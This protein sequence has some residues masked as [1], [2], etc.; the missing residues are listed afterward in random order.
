MIYRKSIGVVGWVCRGLSA[1][2]RS[3]GRDIDVR[4]KGAVPS[5]LTAGDQLMCDFFKAH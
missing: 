5:G 4:G 2:A 1:L 3:L